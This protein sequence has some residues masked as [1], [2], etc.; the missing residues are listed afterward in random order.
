MW[1]PS[2]YLLLCPL[3]ILQILYLL[4]IM[5][6]DTTFKRLFSI[7]MLWIILLLAL[8]TLLILNEITSENY[9]VSLF[10]YCVSMLEICKMPQEVVIVL[11]GPPNCVFIQIRNLIALFYFK[12]PFGKTSA[13][14]QWVMYTQQNSCSVSC[15]AVISWHFSQLKY[16]VSFPIQ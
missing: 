9:H 5:K 10:I 7:R 6:D 1:C 11:P 16:F 4:C 3:F 12:I 8:W 15:I 13:P 2:S 14:Y